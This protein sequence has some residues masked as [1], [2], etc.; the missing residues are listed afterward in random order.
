MS[1][2]VVSHIYCTCRHCQRTSTCKA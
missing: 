2:F 1:N